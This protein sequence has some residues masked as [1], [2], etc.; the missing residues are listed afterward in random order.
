MGEI[1]IGQIVMGMYCTNC[2]FAH[3][4]NSDEAIVFDPA[5]SGEYI[6]KTLADKGMKVKAIMLTHGHFDH[7]YG[8]D[9]LRKL[10]GCEV[11]A[12][13]GET[14]LLSDP[15]LNCSIQVGRPATVVTDVTLKDNEEVTIAD[16]RIKVIHTPGHTA[17]SACYLIE[18]GEFIVSGDTLFNQSI[19]RSDLPTGSASLLIRSVKEKLMTIPDEY[20][21]YPGHG[22]ATTIGYERNNN[23]FL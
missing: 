21:V 18:E 1:K 13:E 3:R 10:A 22:E 19:G 12:Y 14:Q 6:Y 11:Y 16:I 7:I 2:Y 8:V 15:E 17:G 23:P 5:D 20:A 4:D 9:E